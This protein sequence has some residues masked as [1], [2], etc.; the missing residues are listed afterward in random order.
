MEYTRGDGDNIGAGYGGSN[1]SSMWVFGLVVLALF[2]FWGRN[3]RREH[4]GYGVESVVPALAM[5]SMMNHQKPY[6]NGGGGHCIEEKVWDVERDQMREF[7]NVRD[8]VREVGWRNSAENAKYFYDQRNAMCEQNRLIDRGFFEQARLTDRGFYDQ[9]AVID[10]NNYDSALGF[11]Q[12]EIG[13]LIQTKEILGRIDKME[14][15]MK[16]EKIQALTSKV[17]FLETVH[18]VRGWGIPPAYPVH[19]PTQMGFAAC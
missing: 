15:D 14:S 1:W 3:D 12:V 9:R 19:P 2:V 11:K 4:G 6:Y 5:G 16:E 10:R 7:A 17:N 18:G 13:N 8:E